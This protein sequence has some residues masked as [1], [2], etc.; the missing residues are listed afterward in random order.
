VASWCDLAGP[1]DGGANRSGG[2]A[3]FDHP[4]NPRHPVPWYG[5]SSA[6]APE[7]GG[8]YFN[9]ALLFN[10][11]LSLGAGETLTLRYRAY[12]HDGVP[13][14]E[15]LEREYARYLEATRTELVA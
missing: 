14:I 12:V 13:E 9:A 10:E 15:Q 4:H 6:G 11:P 8:H 7:G 5:A 1:L 3:I 2:I